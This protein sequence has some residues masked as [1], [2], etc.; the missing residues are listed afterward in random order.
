MASGGNDILSTYTNSRCN[1][2]ECLKSTSLGN[3]LGRGPASAWEVTMTPGR[4][5]SP[6]ALS[7]AE[8]EPSQPSIPPLNPGGRLC[9]RGGRSALAVLR[10]CGWQA[11]SR[12]RAR[13]S[14]AASAS[15]PPSEG[16]EGRQRHLLTDPGGIVLE[17]LVAAA[18]V[19]RGGTGPRGGPGRPWALPGWAQWVMGRT[20]ARR[21]HHRQMAKN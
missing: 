20:L 17:A 2:R 7:D 11:V 9:T 4:P 16:R 21:G 1:I 14:G 15:R 6:T 3:L 12:P 13:R 5:G 10:G 8:R 18:E 19:G